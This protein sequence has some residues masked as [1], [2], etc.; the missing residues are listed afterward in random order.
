VLN[1]AFGTLKFFDGRVPHLEAQVPVPIAGV[2]EMNLPISEALSRLNNPANLSPSGASWAAR[3][4]T[5]FGTAATETNLKEALALYQRTLNSGNSLF[6]KDLYY[7]KGLA[8]G[9]D[10]LSN[11]QKRGR[12]LFFGKAR[13]FGCHAGSAFSDDDF[14]N[15]QSVDATP[16]PPILGRGGLT[17][18][19]TEFGMLKVPTLRNLPLTAPYFHDG[20]ASALLDVVEHYDRGG[21][22]AD[23]HLALGNADR[24]L[25]PLFLSATERADLVSFLRSLSGTQP[26]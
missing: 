10:V 25:L 22:R 15:V 21:G 2:N 9:A 16:V 6:D 23:D 17:D 26:N 13:C 18:R 3:F 19:E 4:Q 7:R 12:A 14:H 5:A 20:Q 24:Q 8:G 1:S 11:A